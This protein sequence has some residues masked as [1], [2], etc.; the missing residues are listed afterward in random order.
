MNFLSRA[1]HLPL[2]ILLTASIN[3]DLYSAAANGARTEKMEKKMKKICGTVASMQHF[4]PQPPNATKLIKFIKYIDKLAHFEQSNDRTLAIQF[5]S[6][7]CNWGTSIPGKPGTPVWC[8]WGITC[9]TQEDPILR[10]WAVSLLFNERN[11]RLA[12]QKTNFTALF[13]GLFDESALVDLLY[14]FS[15]GELIPIPEKLINENTLL[16]EGEEFLDTQIGRIVWKDRDHRLMTETCLMTSSMLQKP[17][18]SLFHTSYPWILLEDCDP[19]ATKKK[20]C[21]SCLC[22]VQ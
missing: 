4:G 18:N 2:I 13:H 1:R 20:G 16:P 5:L 17:E 3:I 19:A 15:Y 6:Q 21:F 22:T 10:P 7:P 12:S 14:Q 9:P 8:A 11:K